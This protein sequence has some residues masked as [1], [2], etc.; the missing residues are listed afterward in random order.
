MLFGQS[1]SSLTPPQALQLAQAVATLSGAGGSLDFL[2]ATR[3][4][5]GLD[6]LGVKSSGQSLGQSTVAAGKYVA[7]GVYVEASQGLAGTSGA[8]SV[9]V[10]VTKNITI[11]SKIGLDAKTGV[12]I[13]WKFDY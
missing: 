8:V 1:V 6:Y 10:D 3:K 13:N 4:L 2:G 9:E 12:G 5:A 11:E 7:D